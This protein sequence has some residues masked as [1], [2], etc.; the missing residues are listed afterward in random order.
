MTKSDWLQ[1]VELNVHIKLWNIGFMICLLLYLGLICVLYTMSTTKLLSKGSTL[2]HMV[3]QHCCLSVHVVLSIFHVNFYSCYIIIALKMFQ[4]SNG[5]MQGICS[6]LDG[7]LLYPWRITLCG[8]L[9]ISCVVL[10]IINKGS[11]VMVGQ[12]FAR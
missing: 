9:S 10:N 12:N 11:F 7:A 2:V 4:S 5:V 6:K 1:C 8:K 3:F